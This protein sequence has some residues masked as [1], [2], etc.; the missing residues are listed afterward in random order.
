[1]TA[2]RR[3]RT[4]DPAKGIAANH[5]ALSRTARSWAP[6]HRIGR[7][8]MPQHRSIGSEAVAVPPGLA[9]S[10]VRYRGEAGRAWIA[11]LPDFAAGYLDRWRLRL[12]GP[13]R[14][15]VVA[16]VLPVR[17]ADGTPAVLKLQPVDE[18]HVGEAA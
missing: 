10:Q 8:V 15:G 18:E 16:L 2:P 5:A 6:R 12:D 14:H 1:M 3:W 9:T 17:M 7:P 4:P 13:P 11:G